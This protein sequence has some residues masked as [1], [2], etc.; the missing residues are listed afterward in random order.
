MLAKLLY[1]RVNKKMRILAADGEETFVESVRAYRKEEVVIGLRWAGLEATATYGS[2]DGSDFG[3]TS[4]RLIVV[5][6]RSD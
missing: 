4:E 2:F 3:R 1:E 6:R 5:G